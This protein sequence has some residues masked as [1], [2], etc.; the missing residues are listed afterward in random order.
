MGNNFQSL[1][2]FLPETVLILT[3]LFVIISDLIPTI[4]E[5]SFKITLFGLSL[6][7]LILFLLKYSNEYI[8]NDMLVDDQFSFYFKCIILLSTFSIILVSRY[9]KELDDEYRVE[10][11]VLLLIVLFML[12][13]ILS[14]AISHPI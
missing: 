8:F 2:Y 4:K 5:Y 9:Y 1:Q 11:N 7:G 13:I 10:Y 6:T 3:V 14:A 12:S